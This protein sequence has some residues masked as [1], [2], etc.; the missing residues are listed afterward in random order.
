[1]K[2]L[3]SMR[4]ALSDPDL[5]GVIMGGSSRFAWRAVLI[6]A[7]GEALTPDEAE[8]FFRLTGRHE[9]P[10]E[11]IDELWAV[12]GR[13]GGKSSAI[14]ALVIYLSVLCDHSAN[15]AV[16][17]RGVVLVLASNAKQAGVVFSYVA[18]ILESVPALA[19]LVTNKTNEVIS[20]KNG[21]DIEIRAASFRGVRGITAVAVVADEI[22]Y[23]FSDETSRNPDSDILAALRPALATTQGPLIAIGSPYARR[24]ELW[25]TFKKD[26]GAN[27]DPKI[28]VVSRSQLDASAESC[29]SCA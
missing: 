4:G 19:A 28:L 7:L 13:R 29:R 5:L 14:A 16:G 9:A 11:M 21:I 17:E 27:G 6:A 1:V 15:L 22:G 2:P 8:V 18:G 20:L 10:P 3:V 25:K 23:W 12:G 24:G 26:Y